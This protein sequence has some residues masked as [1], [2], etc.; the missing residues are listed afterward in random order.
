MNITELKNLMC[1]IE[2]ADGETVDGGGVVNNFAVLALYTQGTSTDAGYL[3]VEDGN[4]VYKVGSTGALTEIAVDTTTFR[5]LTGLSTGTQAWF[6]VE[7][8]EASDVTI[9][10]G[11]NSNGALPA[12]LGMGYN[13]R[14]NDLAGGKALLTSA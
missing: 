12:S 2:S 13:L 7:K 5:A 3:T 8:A 11:G 14:Y 6:I 4:K 9:T 1:F 10:I